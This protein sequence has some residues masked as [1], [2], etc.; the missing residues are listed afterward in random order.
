MHKSQLIINKF[1]KKLLIKAYYIPILVI[2]LDEM[3]AIKVLINIRE[4]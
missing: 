3:G 1:L 2:P 4:V